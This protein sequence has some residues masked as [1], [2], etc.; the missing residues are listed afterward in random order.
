MYPDEYFAGQVVFCIHS[1]QVFT[2]KYVRTEQ[3]FDENYGIR[4]YENG[5]KS[6]E[7]NE[8]DGFED[9]YKGDIDI[10]ENSLMLILY[11]INNE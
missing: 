10:T 2:V 3:D 6:I 5:W 4:D 11:G 7:F 8:F 1:K 9:A